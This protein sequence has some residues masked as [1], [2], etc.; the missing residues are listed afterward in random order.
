MQGVARRYHIPA[1][2]NVTRVTQ[3]AAAHPGLAMYAASAYT[4]HMTR[5]SV[6]LTDTQIATLKAQAQAR[7]LRMAEMLRRLLDAALETADPLELRPV[8]TMTRPQH[9]TSDQR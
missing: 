4:K 9:Q 8:D 2:K 3:Y 5:I 1:Q 6:F 7:G